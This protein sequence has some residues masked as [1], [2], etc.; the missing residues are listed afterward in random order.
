VMRKNHIIALLVCL[1]TLRIG[2]AG[3]QNKIELQISK[4]MD[5]GKKVLMFASIASVCED[6]DSNLYVLDRM[7]HKVLKFSPEG[8]LLQTFGQKGQGPGDFQ[9]PHLLAY[10]SKGQLVVADELYNLTFLSKEGHFIQRIHLDSRLEVGYIGEDCFYGWI[11]AED[12]RAQV[13]VDKKNNV[14]KNFYQV[15]R[16]AFSVSAPDETGRLVMFNFSRD[17]F[18]PSLEFSHFGH[19]S[20]IGISDKYAIL[21]LDEKGKTK[22]R[23]KRDIPPEKLSKKEKKHFEKEI[24]ELRKDRGWPRSVVRNLVKIIPDRKTFFDRVLLTTDYVF[25]FRIREDVTEE[26]GP[27]PVDV[28]SI[29]GEFLGA[30]FVPDIPLHVSE[31]HMYFIRSDEQDNLCLEKA[32]FKII[33]NGPL[34]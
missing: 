14:L 4:A 27:I 17:E 34:D 25:V 2:I 8:E 19:Y 30:T 12:H 22:T 15:P 16:G 21:I 10:T 11:W 9:N 31:E 23:I 32:A 24:Q 1:F 20:A 26:D 6:P 29:S 5:I 28:F 33:Q 13:V 3:D 7:E 18:T